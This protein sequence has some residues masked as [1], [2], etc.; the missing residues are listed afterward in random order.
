MT[1][2]RIKSKPLPFA[3]LGDTPLVLAST[4][5]ARQAMFRRAGLVYEAV[6][7]GVDEEAL[8]LAAKDE[9]LTPAD[10]ATLL[11][12]AKARA[13]AS[14]RPEA[15][16]VA[17]DQLLV[18]DQMIYTKP[19][20]MAAAEETLAAISG[21]THQLVTAGIMV[22]S[23]ARLWHFVATTHISVRPLSADFIKQ[24]CDYLGESVC[25][26]PGIYM[27]EG[28]GMHIITAIDGCPY[29]ALGFPMLECL[30]HLR[31]LG[32]APLANPAIKDKA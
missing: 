15:V 12:E 2:G 21:K 26:T 9:S 22:Q 1:N 5:Q 29:A 16:V 31:T 7:S 8:L 17:S 23:T 25:A 13:V 11:A 4:S 6:A 27:L 30:A 3:G 18:L 10:T 24:Y 19:K 20:T 32:L 28:L 14:R